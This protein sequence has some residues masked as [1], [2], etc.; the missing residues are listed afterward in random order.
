MG[1]K[2]DIGFIIYTAFFPAIFAEH[3]YYLFR[4]LISDKI[5]FDPESLA[6]EPYILNIGLGKI[7]FR[8][9]EIINGVQEIGFSHSVIA[10]DA[11]NPLPKYE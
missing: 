2:L 6:A 7:A 10:T 11:Y 4:F 1:R 8:E 3:A 5:T 9:A